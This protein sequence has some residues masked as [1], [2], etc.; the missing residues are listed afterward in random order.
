MKNP[1][2]T[3]EIDSSSKKY[4]HDLEK[5]NI[6]IGG[7]KSYENN[8]KACSGKKD[9]FCKAINNTGYEQEDMY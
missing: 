7:D 2:E 8:L 9:K 3:C 4:T 1:G 6:D 5:E